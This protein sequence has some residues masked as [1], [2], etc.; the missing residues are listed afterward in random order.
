MI[1]AV[2]MGFIDM[3][4]LNKVN[5]TKNLPEKRDHPAFL[6]IKKVAQN[7]DLWQAAH[8]AVMGNLGPLILTPFSILLFYEL[9]FSEGMVALI[10]AVST[11]G[12][13]VGQVIGGHYADRLLVRDVF[14]R[15]AFIALLG[16]FVILVVSMGIFSF[17]LKIWI[18]GGILMGVTLVTSAA[19]GAF[20]SA[21]TKY[22]FCAVKDNFSVAFAFINLVSGSAMF[23]IALGAAK[24]GAMLSER[25]EFLTT[26]LWPGCHYIQIVLILSMGASL[27]SL[28]Y[29][30]RHHIYKLFYPES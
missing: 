10:I 23:C 4:F 26:H 28:W 12:S 11:A 2:V 13:A 22:V 5:G 6:E 30:R 7:K 29:L 15:S 25:D 9:K 24:T 16:A 14:S 27:L 18:A 19:S 20:A 8:V 1:F 21:N 17:G 3:W